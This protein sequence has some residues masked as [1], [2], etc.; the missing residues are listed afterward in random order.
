MLPS[1]TVPEEFV[2]IAKERSFVAFVIGLCESSY[3][4]AGNLLASLRGCRFAAAVIKKSYHKCCGT[5][6]LL[7]QMLVIAYAVIAYAVIAY[8]VI[9]YAVEPP[10]FLPRSVNLATSVNESWA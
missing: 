10:G 5:S 3:L 9:A 4:C 2:P 7:S 1:V 8:A 6:T